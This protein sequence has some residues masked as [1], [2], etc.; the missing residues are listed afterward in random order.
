MYCKYCKTNL[1]DIDTCTQIKCLICNTKGHPHWKCPQNKINFNYKNKI[2]LK[3]KNFVI[4]YNKINHISN[5]FP[6]FNLK[7]EE[8]SWSNF[9][10]NDEI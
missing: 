6:F 2:R 9:P 7:K 4:K 10:I 3:K 8:F 1:H 5:D